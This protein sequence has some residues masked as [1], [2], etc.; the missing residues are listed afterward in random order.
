MPRRSLMLVL[1]QLAVAVPFAAV[2]APAPRWA[3]D[4]QYRIIV[5]VSPA[6]IG[7]RSR[8]EAPAQVALDFEQILSGA[9][10]PA[11]ADLSTLQIMRFHPHTGAPIPYQNNLYQETPYDLPLQWHDAAIPDPYPDRDRSVKSPWKYRRG[12]G[13]YYEVNGDWKRGNL[14]WTHVQEGRSSSWYAVYFNL[15]EPGRK[16]TAPAPR[17]WIGDGSHRTAKVGKRSTGLYIPDCKMV[18]FNQDGLPD[19]VCGSSRGAVLWYENLG[20]RSKP[21]FAIARLLFQADGR[22]IDPGFLSTPTV[23]DWDHDGKLDLLLGASKGWIYFYRNVGT[24]QAPLYV[25]QGPLQVAGHDLRTP[26][27]PVPEVAGPHGESIY[28]EDYEPHVEVVDWDGDGND[29]LLVGGYVTGRVYWYRSLG[30]DAHGVPILE[31][32]GPLMADG[33]PIDVGWVASPAAADL[34]GD[35]DLDLIV[36]NWRKWGNESPPEIGEEFLAYYE[37]IGTRR[38]PVL[39]MKPLPRM[40]RFPADEIATPSLADWD[41]D[42]DL[43]LVVSTQSGYLYFFENIGTA[44][45]PKFDARRATPLTMPWGNDPLPVGGDS[46]TPAFTDWTARGRF[47]ILT[48]YYVT[49]NVDARI[50]W[51]F[52][53]PRSILPWGQTID[54]RS[55]RGDDWQYTNVVD[56]DGDGRKDI[57]FG[58]YWGHVWFHKGI[59]KDGEDA[60][61]TQGVRIATE[62]GS[63]VEVGPTGPKAYDFDSM[64]G[65]RTGVVAADFD[66]DG[67]IDL[68]VSDVYGH[69][70][71]CPRG[72]HAAEPRVKSQILFGE[73]KR[74]GSAL[75]ELPSGRRKNWTCPQCP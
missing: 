49:E 63:L 9:K 41:G 2:P 6:D 64:Q 34:D 53:P 70:Y 58:D 72:S 15:L 69:F 60:F 71:F 65:P 1:A 18:D 20:T 24:N 5:E 4:R 7:T 23:T 33:K 38:N 32:R 26:A 50:P 42:G 27:S 28:K 44:R 73:M 31:D 55:W 8:D 52:R 10:L 62:N 57:L 17:G 43:D 3:S 25:D 66:G 29:D 13:Y 54:H 30:R 39:T 12:W 21:R 40:G 45:S 61:D 36:G 14:A 19:L 16:Q 22:P 74:F 37:N 51:L 59:L 75:P 68:V 48:G 35:G 47:D 56:F 11:R 67:G 46:A